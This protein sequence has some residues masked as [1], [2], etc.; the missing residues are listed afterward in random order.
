MKRIL[1]AVAIVLLGAEVTYGQ[2]CQAFINGSKAR[3][4]KDKWEDANQ[5]LAENLGGCTDDAEYR[6]LYGITLAKVSPDSTAKAL[7]ELAVA[8]SLNGNPGAEDELQ[9]NI[10]QAYR[11][12]WGPM[13]NDGVRLLS[14]G[15][16]E[17]AEEKLSTAVEIRPDG[18]EGRLGLGAVHQAKQEYDLAIEQYNKALEIDPTYKQASIRL[19][20]TYQ[21]KAEEAAEAGNTM[22]AEQIAGQAAEVYK[23]YLAE[24][25]DDLE[26]KIQLAGLHATLGDMASAEPIIREIMTSDSV[27]VD[28]FTDFGFRLANAQQLELAE[29]LLS[30]A[31]TMSDSMS[32]EPLQYLAFVKIQQEDLEGAKAV[33]TKQLELEPDNPEA[34]E[35]LGYVRRDLGDTEGAQEAF[36]QAQQIPLQLEGLRLN[37]NNDKTWSV[38]ATFSNRTEEP[39]Q[40]VKVKFVLVSGDGQILETKEADLA[41]QPLP[42]GQAENVTVQFSTPAENPRVRYDIL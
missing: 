12:L 27:N 23:S 18:K 40:N 38:Q 41:G 16:L 25:P 5:V 34:W 9:G 14:E 1:L 37:Q 36:L 10:D 2:T 28:V 8:D 4:S 17:A 15:D 13:V 31:V 30:T 42:A 7:N 22:Q 6:Y 33:L 35:Y 24:N 21:L 32:A 29:E 19:G 39:V 26:V 3:I 20:Q 11:A